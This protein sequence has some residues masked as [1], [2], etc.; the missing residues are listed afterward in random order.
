MKTWKEQL[1]RTKLDIGILAGLL[2]LFGGIFLLFDV[3]ELSDSFQYLHQ[4]VAREPVYA[5]LLQLLTT[6]FKENYT[7]PLGI[8]QNLLAVISIYWLYRRI[9][10]ILDMNWFSN[11][12]VVLLLL[13]PHIVT[14]LVSRTHMIITNSVLTEGIA[15]S[16]YYVWFGMLLSSLMGF[17]RQR[18]ILHTAESLLISVLLS[19]IRG[20]LMIC[21]IVW[22][23]VMLFIS[24]KEKQ[25]K[26]ILLVLLTALLSFGLKTE[27]TKIY[28]Y[29]ESDLYVNTVS[30]K[31]ML[32]ANAV[33][34]ADLEDGR[35]ITDDKLKEA[36]EKIITG[37]QTDGLSIQSA[38]G[39]LIEKANFHEAGHE[40]INFDY[41][42]PALNAYTEYQDGITESEYFSLLIK[43]DQYAG[44]IFSAIFPNILSKFVKNYFCIASLGFVR[45]V[46]VDRSILSIYALCIYVAAAAFVLILLRKDWKSRS[47]WFMILVMLLICGTVFGTSIMIECI[48]RYMIYNLP[49]FY[50]AGLAMVNEWLARKRKDRKNG[51]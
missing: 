24:F 15:V 41:I 43:Q 21:I 8:L 7:I 17:Y 12:L 9:S 10:E 23:I 34:V 28:N 5:L 42:V 30:S 35:S 32:L 37:I 1:G 11:I 22:T 51:I 38:S 46:A 36:Y 13:S 40:I 33:Y 16:L 4:F 6:L 39:N 50:I 45:S 26:K 48:S 18:K 49:L 2:L 31:P 25:Y 44:E 27:L 14:P 47:A 19:M 20:Q 29:L 3:R